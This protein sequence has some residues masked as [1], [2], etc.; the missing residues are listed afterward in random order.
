MKAFASAKRAGLGAKG[1][2]LLA[3]IHNEGDVNEAVLQCHGGDHS[4]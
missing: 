1:L 3:E 4:K 2:V